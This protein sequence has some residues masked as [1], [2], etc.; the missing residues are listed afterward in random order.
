MNRSAATRVEY[1]CTSEDAERLLQA[2]V[3]STVTISFDLNLSTAAVEILPDGIRLSDGRTV[4]RSDLETMARRKKRVF[5]LTPDGPQALEIARDHYA[6]LSPTAGAPTLE[7]DG[8]QMH[9][10]KDIDP[11]EDSRL[12]VEGTVRRG[13]T[14]LDTCGGLG[15]TAI[16]AARKGAERVVS[17]EVYDSV[18]ELRAENPWSREL[19]QPP[20]EMVDGDAF[21]VVRSMDD[22]SFDAVIHDPPR[23]SLAGELYSGEFYCHLFRILKRGGRLFHYTGA[24]HS[25]SGRRDVPAEVQRR[26]QAAGFRTRLEPEK[27][28]IAGRK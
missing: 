5:A 19:Y 13:D 14:V 10:T 2:D 4:D 15:Y 26:L 17:V 24:P 16:W 8:V 3:E 27:L 28:G 21:E 22:A 20:I 6:K 25:R 23:F 7:I 9:R 18:R 1:L 11:F 12:K